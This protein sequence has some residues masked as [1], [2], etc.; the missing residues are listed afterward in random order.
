M[1]GNGELAR[2]TVRKAELL[3]A[4]EAHRQELLANCARLQP[5]LAKVETGVRLARRIRPLLL[6]GAPLLGFWAARRGRGGAWK[7]LR[8]GWQ[9]WLALSA[10]WKGFR[11]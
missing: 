11:L 1:F 3:A 7:K 9:V 5:V 10:V 6:A 8:V 2:L 4:S